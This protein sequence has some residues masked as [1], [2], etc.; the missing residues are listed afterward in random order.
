M[1]SA[2]HYSTD[3]YLNIHLNQIG[4]NLVNALTTLKLCLHQREVSSC[5][6]KLMPA[7]SL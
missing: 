1:P 4:I 5:H 2:I 6:G 3:K 7:V